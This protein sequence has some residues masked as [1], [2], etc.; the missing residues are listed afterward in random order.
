MKKTAWLAMVVLLSCVACTAKEAR[1]KEHKNNPVK[2]HQDNSI[3][4]DFRRLDANHDESITKDEAEQNGA[5]ALQANFDKFDANKDGKLSLQE[6]TA[7]V[8][9]QREEDTRRKNET[10][11]R[12]DANHDG[13]ISKEESEKEKDPFLIINFE[14]IDTNKD[15]KMSLQELN[16][17]AVEPPKIPEQP[18]IPS[19]PPKSTQHGQPKQHG[20]PGPLFIAADKDR[21]GTLSKDELKD[22][23]ELYQNFDNIDADHDGKVTTNEIVSYV[24]AH[25]SLAQ[26]QEKTVK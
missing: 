20:Q 4:E 8:L 25:P 12:I 16:T 14:A 15:G 18:P 5:P 24:N 10:F 3:V 19:Q 21:N 17:F 1:E 23:P 26:G 9:A 22:R 11:R 7:F 2:E 13:G 6:V